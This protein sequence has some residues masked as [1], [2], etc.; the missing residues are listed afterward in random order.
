M[1]T[2]QDERPDAR[3]KRV[4]GRVI[5]RL[6]PFIFVGYVIAYIDRV[7]IGFAA[8][9]MQKDLGM[10]DAAYGLGAGLFFLGYV[11]F[12][13]PSNLLLEK[14]G[15][16]F[17][18]AR[19]M[20]VWGLVSMAMSLVQGEVL[21]YALRVL[22]GI[23]E[24][25][26]FP[27]MVLYL[28]YWI[29]ARHRARTGA[30]FMMAIPVAM[31]VGAPLSHALLGLH[32]MAGLAG[33]QWLFLAEGLP[34]VLLGIAALFVLTDRP[35]S[36]SWL[37]GGERQWLDEEMGRE[38]AEGARHHSLSFG[39][40]KDPRVLV[41]GA[42][43]FLNN[44]ATYGVFLFLPK[45]LSEVS[46]Q[47][48]YD[49][50]DWRVPLFTA[51]PFAF[52]LA[53][54]VLVGRHSD[55]TGE[56]TWHVG[57][58]AA[59]A[60]LGLMVAAVAQNSVL[61]VVFAFTLSQVGQRSLLSV[62]WTIPPLFLGGSAAAAGIALINSIGNLGGYLGPSVMGWLRDYSQDYTA[63]LLVLAGALIVEALLVISMRLPARTPVRPGIAERENAPPGQP[64]RQGE[65]A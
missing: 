4:I 14:V 64:E 55:R 7:N 23:A 60:S 9:A 42:I 54:M 57:V 43:Y 18:I 34:A 19:I 10:T 15:A 61:L 3:E 32:G 13:I 53:G 31:L 30:L 44:M 24:A 49:S 38:R 26:F 47:S 39:L 27:G 65:E 33:W 12:E 59:V 46:R 29:P 63:G 25:G 50:E 22:L 45:I 1:S 35:A 11:L 51:V 6:I 36:A 41:L 28:T 8:E 48:G 40:L 56:R 58:C 16:R 20:V 37:A 21:F 17:L 52:A 62:F 2:H 5:R